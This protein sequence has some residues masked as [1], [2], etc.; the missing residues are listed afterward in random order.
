MFILSAGFLRILEKYEHFLRENGVFIISMYISDNTIKLWRMI[1]RRYAVGDEV[2]VC[3]KTRVGWIVK[4]IIPKN[5]CN[6]KRR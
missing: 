1:D 5:G 2:K 4:L 3:N 6:Q